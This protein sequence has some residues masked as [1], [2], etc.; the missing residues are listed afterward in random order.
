MIDE[1]E[2]TEKQPTPPSPARSKAIFSPTITK[3]HP[4]LPDAGKSEV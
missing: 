4:G 3:F 1:N 2:N